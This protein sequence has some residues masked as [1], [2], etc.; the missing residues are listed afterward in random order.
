[1][2]REDYDT[3]VRRLLC[4]QEAPLIEGQRHI[5]SQCPRCQAIWLQRGPRQ[6]LHLGADEIRIWVT[7]LRADLAHLPIRA[8]RPCQLRLVGGEFA[9]DEYAD[10]TSGA[11]TGYGISWEQGMPPEHFLVTGIRADWFLQQEELPPPSIVTNAVLAETALS[12]L[13][14]TPRSSG[15]QP[16]PS[17]L[18]TLLRLATPPGAHAPG[19]DAWVWQGACWTTPCPALGGDLLVMLAQAVPP[20]TSFSLQHAFRRWQAITLHALQFGIA[21]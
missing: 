19:T 15:V 14:Q 8:C 3:T 12:A 4:G 13:L 7:R 18:C 5:L 6:N 2:T 20:A 21:S 16:L 9:L 10:T 11:I 1:M 17:L